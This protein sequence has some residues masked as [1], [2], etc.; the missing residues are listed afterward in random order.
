MSPAAT[1]TLTC[2]ALEVVEV[3]PMPGFDRARVLTLAMLASSEADQ[4][5]IDAAIR[6]AAAGELRS[7]PTS[8]APECV[9][10]YCASRP[11]SGG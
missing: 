8:D 5:P 11:G 10:N 6:A 3:R 2:N 7:V 4:D 1:G 9:V